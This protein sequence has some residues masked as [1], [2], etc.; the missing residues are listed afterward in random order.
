MA[1]VAGVFAVRGIRSDAGRK[2]L[3]VYVCHL[4]VVEG[5]ALLASYWWW[6]GAWQIVLS[7]A[8]VLFLWF[9]ALLLDLR[10]APARVRPQGF[11]V[12]GNN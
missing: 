3:A 6:M 2:S 7:V 4:W 5:V 8:A 1:A 11:A 10:T 12:A 9:F